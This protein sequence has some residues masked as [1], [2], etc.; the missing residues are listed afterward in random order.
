MFRILKTKVLPILI[1]MAMVFSTEGMMVG[2]ADV[3]YVTA[4]KLKIRKSPDTE[5]DELATLR[6]NDP[7]IVYGMQNGW[8]WIRYGDIS[9]FVKEIRLTFDDQDAIAA[10]ESGTDD[11]KQTASN[12]QTTE[13]ADNVAAKQNTNSETNKKSAKKKNTTEKKSTGKKKK[14]SG[15]NTEKTSQSKPEPE[16]EI[17]LDE[18]VVTETVYGECEDYV[19][20][21]LRYLENREQE[22]VSDEYYEEFEGYE[23]DELLEK[24]LE[25]ND[26]DIEFADP[27]G[28]DEDS[29]EFQTDEQPDEIEGADM[30]EAEDQDSENTE[31]A[32]QGEDE[33]DE[34]GFEEDG[35]DEDGF[36][37]QMEMSEEQPFE[38]PDETNENEAL[39]GEA[40][41]E[42]YEEVIPYNLDY[43]EEANGSNY[44]ISED[45]Q[46]AVDIALGLV[47]NPYVYGGNDPYNGIDCSGF[48]QYIMGQLGINTAR[49]AAEQQYN[50]VPIDLQDVTPGD[51]LF[52]DGDMDGMI[53]H[54]SMYIGGGQIVHASD[55]TTGII[56]TNYD[57]GS[58][59]VSAGTYFDY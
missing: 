21:Y 59:P 45:R 30:N 23:E 41:D 55:E 50:S 9:G 17:S 29:D 22:S 33:S 26:E 5:S 18:N 47:G 35:V 37:E 1:T 39:N 14:S 25:E 53:D 40:E 6:E 24:D 31:V 43:E 34:A 48:T 3:A 7:V 36:E 15:K 10:Y 4:D 56:V 58:A 32:D 42:D 52:Y 2:A 44:E 54:V 13:K 12:V 16:T 57:Y 49:T 11:T 27:A 20:S 46:R 28:E 8:C 19:D 51:C 38:Y